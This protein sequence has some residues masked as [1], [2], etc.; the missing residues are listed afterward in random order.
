MPR[1]QI[2]GVETS[3]MVRARK[4]LW[5]R[6]AGRRKY[7]HSQMINS[8]HMGRRLLSSVSIRV[9]LTMPNRGRAAEAIFS[10]IAGTHGETYGA[11]F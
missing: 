9:V 4:Y 2:S 1:V 3:D 5:R 10:P 7:G 8:V 6:C 11:R